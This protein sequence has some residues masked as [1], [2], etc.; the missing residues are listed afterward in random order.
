[1]LS[2]FTRLVIGAIAGAAVGFALVPFI[3]PALGIVGT[4]SA[5]GKLPSQAELAYNPSKL[6]GSILAG[7]NMVEVGHVAALSL[8]AV[9]KYKALSGAE[10]AGWGALAAAGAGPLKT[11][12]HIIWPVRA[13]KSSSQWFNVELHFGYLQIKFSESATGRGSSIR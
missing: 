11:V 7:I 5:A 4:T 2:N 8:L 13:V 12:N 9:A 3:A 1:M 10:G 6:L